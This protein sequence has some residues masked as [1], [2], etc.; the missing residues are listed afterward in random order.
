MVRVLILDRRRKKNG[1]WVHIFPSR[2]GKG[3]IP[4]ERKWDLILWFIIY[5][6]IKYI[7]KNP[8]KSNEFN[9]EKLILLF[10]F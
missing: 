5:I 6:Y 7:L 9:Q 4:L 8:K 1:G 2:L 10:M 3:V